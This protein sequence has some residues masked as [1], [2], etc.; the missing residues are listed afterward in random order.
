MDDQPSQ[1][2]KWR[3]IDKLE[4]DLSQL[5]DN[6]Q[7][8]RMLA[9]GDN[10]YAIL[11]RLDEIRRLQQRLAVSHGRVAKQM[12]RDL[13]EKTEPF[14]RGIEEQDEPTFAS[15]DVH[16]FERNSSEIN[17]LL[18]NLHQVHESICSMEK[19]T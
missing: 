13:L 8:G 16:F 9:F 10:T 18:N 5:S 14:S 19:K 7:E 1:Q 2:S 15:D 6:F 17:G 3:S 4:K 11:S 12:E